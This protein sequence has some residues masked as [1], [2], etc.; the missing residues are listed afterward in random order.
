MPP[1]RTLAAAALVG[2]LLSGVAACAPGA[3]SGQSEGG[4]AGSGSAGAGSSLGWQDALT[5]GLD[6]LDVVTTVD[7][8][9]QNIAHEI[10]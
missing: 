6:R 2:A 3:G 7:L 8:N 1:S 10:V 5:G 4:N 9:C